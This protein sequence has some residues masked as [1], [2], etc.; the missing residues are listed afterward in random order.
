MQVRRSTWK[1]IGMSTGI[2]VMILI[3]SQ[4]MYESWFEGEPY[5][6]EEEIDDCKLGRVSPEELGYPEKECNELVAT[7]DW[8]ETP[9]LVLCNISI[10]SFII[11]IFWKD[12]ITVEIINQHSGMVDDE[13]KQK[14]EKLNE[15]NTELSHLESEL[16]TTKNDIHSISLE[17]KNLEN[18]MQELEQ[19]SIQKSMNYE[20][21]LQKLKSLL[22]KNKHDAELAKKAHEEA[23]AAIDI[24]RKHG[25]EQKTVINNTNISDSVI[26]GNLNINSEDDNNL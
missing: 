6:T 23:E 15:V 21:E 7:E 3:I 17:R 18:Q 12:K 11:S 26:M 13:L 19:T 16:K 24:L 8:L 20:D 5:I 14:L 9:V 10:W 2:I 4:L 1:K 25:F 22:E